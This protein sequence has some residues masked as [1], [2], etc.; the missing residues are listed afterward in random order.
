MH[1]END[2]PYFAQPESKCI[3]S[4]MPFLVHRIL[5]EGYDALSSV[6]GLENLKKAAFNDPEVRSTLSRMTF[7]K[8]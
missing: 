1:L 4:S 5:E 2:M 7:I 6:P 3:V 8:Q